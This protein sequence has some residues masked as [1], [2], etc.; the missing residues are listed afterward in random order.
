VAGS[1]ASGSLEA[2]TGQVRFG[3]HV[4][5]NW[6]ARMGGGI[7]RSGVLADTIETHSNTPKSLH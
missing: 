7:G 2:N 6:Q 4:N 3:L 1:L 5:L